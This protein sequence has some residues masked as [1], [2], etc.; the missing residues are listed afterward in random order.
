[1]WFECMEKPDKFKLRNSGIEIFTKIEL[2]TLNTERLTHAFRFA[3][4]LE[5]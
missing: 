2:K 5:F 4:K 1:M 3:L